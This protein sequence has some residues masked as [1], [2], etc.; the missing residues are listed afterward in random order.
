MLAKIEQRAKLADVEGDLKKAI[1]EFSKG[2]RPN[3]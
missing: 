3:A 2:F 1:E